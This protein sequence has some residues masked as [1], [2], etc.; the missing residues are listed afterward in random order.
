M[1]LLTEF[2]KDLITIQLFQS[3]IIGNTPEYNCDIYY[4]YLSL[5][6]D[7]LHKYAR[8]IRGIDLITD[9]QYLL[10]YNYFSGKII[11]GKNIK[12]DKSL[13]NLIYDIEN[14]I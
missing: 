3:S 1:L 10:L 2:F 5:R 13:Y 8:L 4:E 7:F 11:S 14:A 9:D 6:F 12:T